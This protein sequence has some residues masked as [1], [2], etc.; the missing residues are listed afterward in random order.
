MKNCVRRIVAH[1]TLRLS[2]VIKH[3][4]LFSWQDLNFWPTVQSFLLWKFSIFDQN[5]DFCTK[6]Q[7]DQSRFSWF[8]LCWI[9][10]HV[11]FTTNDILRVNKGKNKSWRKIFVCQSFPSKIIWGNT[12]KFGFNNRKKN[13]TFLKFLEK[14]SGGGWKVME[15]WRIVVGDFFP[16]GFV[17]CPAG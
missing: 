12:H 7:F 8:F 16:D 13:K 14:K 15:V 10:F 4:C 5:F 6:F 2:L 3:R 1:I 11:H 17:M 9:T